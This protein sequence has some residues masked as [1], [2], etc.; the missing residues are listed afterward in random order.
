MS[1]G[2]YRIRGPGEDARHEQPLEPV[3]FP[4]YDAQKLIN[5]SGS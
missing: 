1:T 2:R 4:V 5:Q 3:D